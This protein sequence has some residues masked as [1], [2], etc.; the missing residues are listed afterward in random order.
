MYSRE[1]RYPFKVFANSFKRS[2]VSFEDVVEENRKERNI[3]SLMR[4]TSSLR[5]PSSRI[6]FRFVLFFLLLKRND[7]PKKKKKCQNNKVDRE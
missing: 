6:F 5:I 1:L 4:L 7:F 2:A 3:A